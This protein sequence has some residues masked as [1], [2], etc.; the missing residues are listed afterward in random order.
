[1]EVLVM[2][3]TAENYA[4]WIK[5]W[6]EAELTWINDFFSV[7]TSRKETKNQHQNPTFKTKLIHT[8]NFI[9]RCKLYTQRILCYSNCTPENQW[10]IPSHLSFIPILQSEKIPIVN[11]RHEEG[12]MTYQVPKL[13]MEIGKA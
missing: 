6:K 7:M 2:F 10:A 3:L 8:K 12:F 4:K 1:M 11:R 5:I 13:P 9:K